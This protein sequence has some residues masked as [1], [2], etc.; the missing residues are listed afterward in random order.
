MQVPSNQHNLLPNIKC[1]LS[2]VP[3]SILLVDFLGLQSMS[4]YQLLDVLHTL[5]FSGI[6]TL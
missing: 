2:T 6:I 5:N 3:I 4:M 1:N